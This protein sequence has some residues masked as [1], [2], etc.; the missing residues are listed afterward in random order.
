VR[1]SYPPSS[2]CVAKRW[3]HQ[4]NHHPGLL[5]GQC[6]GIA[7]LNAL[8]HQWNHHDNIAWEM[9]GELS[10]LN[11][12]RHQWNH[13]FWEKDAAAGVAVLNALRHQWNHHPLSVA[14]LLVAKPCST[15]CGIN[16]I[17]TTRQQR[18]RTRSAVRAQ[19]L[20]ASID[21]IGFNQS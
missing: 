16:G 17:I 10:V 18:I 4:W 7:V 8:R 14:L 20:A 5:V 13:H 15:P 3:W 2:T 19:R 9:W 11:A 21:I 6:P 1:I 12:L